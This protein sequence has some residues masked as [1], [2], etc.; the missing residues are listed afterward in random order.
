[1]EPTVP[2][3][4]PW[5]ASSVGLLAVGAGVVLA[6]RGPLPDLGAV[7]LFGALVAFAENRAVEFPNGTTLSANSLA[8]MAAVVVFYESGALLG[9]LL[10]GMCGAFYLPALREGDW[11]KMVFNLGSYGLGTLVVASVFGVL[12]SVADVSGP[13]LLLVAVPVA[14]ASVVVNDALVAVAVSLDQE[15][16]ARDVLREFRPGDWQVLPFTLLGLFMGR[17]YLEF[18]AVTILLF[19]VSILVARQTFGS[20]LELK[21]AHEATLRALIRALE[22][23]DRH[24]AGHVERVAVYAAYIGAELRL[25]PAK[26]ERLRFAALMHD[27]GKLIVPNHLLNKPG[28]LTRA[29]F[30]LVRRHEPVSVEILSH[31]DFLRD[32]AP[33]ALSH[34]ARYDATDKP[35]NGPIE[36]HIVHVADAYDA[37]TSTR[38]YRRALS[39]E[40]V[41]AEL[42]EKA[43]TQFNPQCVEALI[44]AIERRGEQHGAGFER[45]DDLFPFPPPDLGIGS[46]GLGDFADDEPI[47]LEA[48][49]S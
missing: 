23:K 42:R 27:V 3:R 26:L 8:A 37:M 48:G 49:G 16:P 6:V 28:R 39:Q 45:H 18:G 34:V 14:F 33:S 36:A 32:V 20:Y 41:F 12:A 22:A 13:G 4:F 46:A 25:S 15:R 17:L 11:R 30:E 44:S 24:T 43:G 7:L 35:P 19:I 10:V 21:E 9:P 31:I 29:E 40:V 38:P 1:M 5:F 47:P 2:S